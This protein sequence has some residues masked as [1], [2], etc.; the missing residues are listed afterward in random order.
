MVTSCS[1]RFLSTYCVLHV[2][3]PS[4]RHLVSRLTLS[5]PSA[6]SL[7]PECVGNLTNV[8]ASTSCWPGYMLFCR[9]VCDI[10]LS[11]GPRSTSSMNQTCVWDVTLWTPGWT[12][13]HRVVPTF[14]LIGYPG[15]HSGRCCPSVYMVDELTMTLIRYLCLCVEG[16]QNNT[17]CA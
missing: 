15:V 9:S 6:P 17:H 8:L 5:V 10:L 16:K 1:C 7:P 12:A 2:S 3:S 4:S 13:Q 14:L 11:A